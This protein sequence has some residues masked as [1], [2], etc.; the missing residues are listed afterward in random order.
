MKHMDFCWIPFYTE[1]ATKLLQYKNN[2][3][4][5]IEK[6]ISIFQNLHT[7]TPTLEKENALQDIDPFTIFG[8]FNKGITD[9]NRI[10]ILEQIA[11][12]FDITAKVPQNF[13][14]I[15]LLNNQKARFYYFIGERGEHDIDCLWHTFSAALQYADNPTEK[16]KAE[17][18]KW[19]DIVIKQKGVK[20][21]ITMGLYW[22]RPQCFIS[23]DTPN[24]NFLCN[25]K[26]MPQ[27]F[28]AAIDGLKQIPSGEQ[29]LWICDLSL[30]MMQN[31]NY[32]YHSFAELSYHAWLCA[33]KR[34][35]TTQNHTWK[36]FP[37]NDIQKPI[38]CFK[39][40]KNQYTKHDFCQEVYLSEQKYDALLHILKMKQNIILQ[41]VAGVGKTFVATRLAYAM[42]GKKDTNR[43]K[44][45][46]FHQN[47]SYE[48]FMMGFRP[49][50]TGFALKTGVFYDFCK[51]AEKDSTNTYF[52]IIDEI[53]RGNLSKIFGEL[54]MLL[55]SDKR[56]TTLELMYTNENFSV[57]NN[58]YIIGTMNTSDRSLAMLDYALRRRFAF[59]TL[60]PAF[61]SSGFQKYQKNI[62]N[63]KFDKLINCIQ[64]L[65]V[66]I[67]NDDT[68]GDGFLIGHSYFCTKQT[69]DDAFL[70]AVV[71]YECMPLLK[72][73]W[74]DEPEKVQHWQDILRSAI[75]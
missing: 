13:D 15:P 11:K 19:F 40:N 29:Y 41:G 1:F 54:F 6:I 16:N 10:A 47:Y 7:K 21:N 25:L 46:Q 43:I 23:L 31:Q 56:G 68:L 64:N 74:F 70:S 3:N 44:I 18:A 38:I 12:L 30:D 66:A 22:I 55:E 33:N 71:E 63:T 32:D 65:N 52:F 4:L 67:Q 50:E 8:L 20:W 42:M 35:K 5:L 45:I 14:G 59:F 9:S 53:N 2:R 51:M 61:A 39:K 24:R 28:V 48:D 69:V 27:N 72:E 26:N 17:M 57:P 60:E 73:Y 37:Q 36:I 75:Q 34:Q 58:V 49:T 62:H